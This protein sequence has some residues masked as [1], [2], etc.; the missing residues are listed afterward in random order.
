MDFAF[1]A[2]NF[3]YSKSDYLALTQTEKLFIVKAYENK[4]VADSNVLNMAV[5][6]AVANVLRKK[7]KRPQKLWKRKS[8]IIVDKEVMQSTIKQII[9]HEQQTGKGWVEKIYKANGY[10]VPAQK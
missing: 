2:V 6:N 9:K 1:F 3:G 7:G 10:K 4:V 5:A 8:R